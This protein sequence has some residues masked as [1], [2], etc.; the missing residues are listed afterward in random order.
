MEQW[1]A[2]KEENRRR[3]KWEIKDAKEGGEANGREGEKE[4][5]RER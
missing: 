5:A 2:Y 3:T 1:T 4:R